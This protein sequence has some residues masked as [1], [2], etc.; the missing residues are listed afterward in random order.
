MVNNFTNLN[1]RLDTIIHNFNR[2]IP[3][4]ISGDNYY[5]NYDKFVF[6]ENNILLVTGLSGSGK[7]TIAKKL[8]EQNNATLYEMDQFNRPKIYELFKQ[9]YQD[10]G[11]KYVFEGVQVPNLLLMSPVI[12][13]LDINIRDLSVIIMRTSYI[14]TIIQ[15]H[16]RGDYH[17]TDDQLPTADSED[18]K[19]YPYLMDP[20][21]RK[22]WKQAARSG[23]VKDF[24]GYNT[25]YRYTNVHELY[26]LYWRLSF[27]M[28]NRSEESLKYLNPL[29]KIDR[30]RDYKMI[31][32][33]DRYGGV[34]DE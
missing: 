32:I 4:F 6:G 10:K 34:K 33:E 22:L 28:E 21:Y 23:G 3:R 13:E 30:R 17:L 26:R 9:A 20:E 24:F 11:N 12:K 1:N 14:K 8:S 25:D 16:K 7:S 19:K 27:D 31:E 29:D 5:H 15:R 2:L 18:A